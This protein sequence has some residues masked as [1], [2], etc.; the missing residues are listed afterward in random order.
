MSPISVIFSIMIA[1]SSAL[2]DRDAVQNF[3][4]NHENLNTLVAMA[5]SERFSRVF[6]QNDPAEFLLYDWSSR[7]ENSKII[8]S[9]FCG[10]RFNSN[11]EIIEAPQISF[12]FDLNQF[13]ATDDVRIEGQVGNFGI[14]FYFKTRTA[15]DDNGNLIFI[16]TLYSLA[17]MHT[18]GMAEDSYLRKYVP[19][20]E[21]A[22]GTSETLHG[23]TTFTGSWISPASE[24]ARQEGMNRFAMMTGVYAKKDQVGVHRIVYRKA[25]MTRGDHKMSSINDSAEAVFSSL[26]FLHNYYKGCSYFNDRGQRISASACHDIWAKIRSR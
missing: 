21:S 19:L 23:A 25:L 16:K 11:F 26:P 6:N 4:W 14:R 13:K 1:S 3:E 15:L 20:I 10:M 8:I 24:I 5:C 9:G 22:I 2:A 17:P 12:V 18:L 7:E